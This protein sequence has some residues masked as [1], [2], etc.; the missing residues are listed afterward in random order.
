MRFFI[1][2]SSIV[3][4]LITCDI[5]SYYYS[6]EVLWCLRNSTE[7]TLVITHPYVD[8]PII[9]P[10][11][12]LEPVFDEFIKDADE[13]FEILPFAPFNKIDSIYVCDIDG[14]HLCTWKSSDYKVDVRGVYNGGFWQTNFVELE[15]IKKI[16]HINPFAEFIKVY[17]YEIREEDLNVSAQNQAEEI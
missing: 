9:I 5:R 14:R 2:F 7:N 3:T 4:L 12:K 8:N 6:C 15:S 10:P 16:K 11:G 17:E 1:L 13:D